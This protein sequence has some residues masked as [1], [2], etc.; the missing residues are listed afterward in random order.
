MEA[1]NDAEKPAEGGNNLK[2]RTRSG[3]E[4][5]YYSERLKSKLKAMLFSPA[6][7]V[8]APSGYGKTTVIRDFL[9]Q[10]CRKARPFTGLPPR[11]KHL[12]RALG[13][14]AAKSIK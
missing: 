12:P 1:P 7:V 13:A 9:K 4:P 2:Q 8:E 10:N 11:K 14:C 6:S 5:H 3:T